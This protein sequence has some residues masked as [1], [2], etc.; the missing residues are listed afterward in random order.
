MK[1]KIILISLVL[2][3]SLSLVCAEE[4]NTTDI[5]EIDDAA[6][7]IT[8][9]AISGNGI[10][11]SDDFI[12]FCIDLTK[13]DIGSS[14]NFV[15][16]EFSNS[17]VEND[18]K[19]AIIECYKQ[20]KENDIKD[21]VSK[22]VNGDASIIEDVSDEK[23]GNKEV[24][25]INNDTEATFEFELLKST[26]DAKSDCVAYK[27]SMKPIE[28][29]DVLAVAGNDSDEKQTDDGNSD[30][31][32]DDKQSDDNK[33]NASNEDKAANANTDKQSD[34][35][36]DNTNKEDKTEDTAKNNK[37]NGNEN[38]VVN[39]TNTTIVNKTNTLIVNENNTTI[40][41]NNNVKTV[42]N[43]NE[44]PENDTFSNLL[45]TAGNPIFILIIVIIVIVIA[46]AVSRRKD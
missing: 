38:T 20:G 5:A 15:L 10:E 43:T 29:K 35:N 27:V 31:Q 26:D 32:N 24:V 45:K 8:P 7:Y 46:V 23:I 1:W 18:I 34:D 13:E 36:K 41:N 11:F 19:L 30:N 16:G 40:V 9:V 6:N 28:K 12:G 21:I 44:T 22:V 39:E 37:S 42:N 33:D 2:L 4:N 25:E 17:K 3:F 14:D